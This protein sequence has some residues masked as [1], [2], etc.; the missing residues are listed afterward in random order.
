M[1]EGL[2]PPP[3]PRPTPASTCCS[4]HRDMVWGLCPPASSPPP[5]PLSAHRQ[6]GLPSVWLLARARTLRRTVL[7]HGPVAC[8]ERGSCLTGLLHA[9]S[10][11][12]VSRACCTQRA[13][14]GGGGGPVSRASC[15]QGAWV[16]SHKPVACRERGS[17]LTG[18]LHTGSR[19]PVSRACCM[20]GAGVLS[21]GPGA[22]KERGFL[23]HGPVARRERLRNA[24][25][26]LEKR[27]GPERPISK[28]KHTLRECLSELVPLLKLCN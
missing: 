26:P 16:L 4:T 5:L 15:M 20:Q 25:K 17:S 8:R 21:H 13:G 2:C 6:Q 10:G 23:S 24:R 12:P 14:G 1:E 9:E 22:C 27:T 18:L 11:G 19:D 28:G 3:P 7:S